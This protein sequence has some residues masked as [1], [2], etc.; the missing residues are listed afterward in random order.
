MSP[1]EALA[2]DF[3]K[4]SVCSPTT[5]A[6]A[7]M[8]AAGAL[9]VEVGAGTVAPMP[10]WLARVAPATAAAAVSWGDGPSYRTGCSARAMAKDELVRR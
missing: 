10:K 5:A 8:E 3:A 7:D 4:L 9:G 1:D 2:I 6:A